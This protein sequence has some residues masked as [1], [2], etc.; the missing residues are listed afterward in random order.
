[1]T[2]AAALHNPRAPQDDV[3]IRFHIASATVTRW[4]QSAV[5]H[6]LRTDGAEKV[7]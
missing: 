4:R 3:G 1:M 2:N 5:F 6:E 7:S